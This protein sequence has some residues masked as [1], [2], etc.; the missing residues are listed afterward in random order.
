[1]RYGRWPPRR[2][3]RGLWPGLCLLGRARAH[4]DLIW[5]KVDRGAA[6][7]RV[8]SAQ[9]TAAVIG[10]GGIDRKKKKKKPCLRLRTWP[11]GLNHP[12][13]ERGVKSMVNA[14]NSISSKA[15][16][17]QRRASSSLLTHGRP[18][19]CGIECRQPHDTRAQQSG[20][21][22]RRPRQK[23]Y[24]QTCMEP[25]NSIIPCVGDKKPGTS[26]TR[27]LNLFQNDLDPVCRW[28]ECVLP[29]LGH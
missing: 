26:A 2:A 6:R 10:K 28:P 17:L 3:G 14:E 27:K 25:Y 24:A 22:R 13:L 4:A 20:P 12:V 19:A 7:K 9:R 1:M 5:P 11:Q 18:S 8:C 15:A 29:S 16:L 23:N 21:P